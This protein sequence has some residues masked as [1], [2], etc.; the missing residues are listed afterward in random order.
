LTH[1]NTLVLHADKKPMKEAGQVGPHQTYRNPRLSTE[2]RELCSL[3]KENIRVEMIYAGI[4]GTDIHATQS[5]PATG[6]I[7]GSAPLQIG[8][9]GRVLGHEGVGRILETGANNSGLSPGDYVTFTSILTCYQCKPCRKG[10][11]NQCENAILFGM[12]KD[13]LFGTIV[14]VPIQLVYKVNRLAEMEFGL[15]AAA[16]IEPAGCGYVAATLAKVSPGDNVLIFG[17]GPIGVFT[18]MLCEEVFGAAQV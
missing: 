8:A 4:C 14:D 17:A 18:A 7:L 6:Y 9:K 11:F 5:N 10:D 16:C 12:E 1:T 13:G 3:A 2:T 15:Q